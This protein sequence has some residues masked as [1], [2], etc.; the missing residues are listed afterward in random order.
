M[1][2]YGVCY[3]VPIPAVVL[4]LVASRVQILIP[5]RPAAE[6]GE[7]DSGVPT[8]LKLILDAIEHGDVM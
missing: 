6:I 2:R 1:A 5:G 7:A 3:Q 8:I 4:K